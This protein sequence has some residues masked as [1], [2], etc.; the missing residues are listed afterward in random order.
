MLWDGDVTGDMS[1]VRHNGSEAC[2]MVGVGNVIL[3]RQCEN[4]L[5]IC[6]DNK[7]LILLA[8]ESIHTT[9]LKWRSVMS[10]R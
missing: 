3:H 7:I 2:N 6:I 5:R 9:S 8:K 1:G 10:C 4:S